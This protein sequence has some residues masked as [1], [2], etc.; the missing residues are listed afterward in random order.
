[1]ETAVTSRNVVILSPDTAWNSQLPD[2]A[3]V[4]ITDY[5]LLSSP[6]SSLL[7]ATDSLTSLVFCKFRGVGVG[8]VPWVEFVVNYLQLLERNLRPPDREEKLHF[9]NL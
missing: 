1:M 5:S 4:I 8:S 7:T 9:D 2:W 6:L 3:L